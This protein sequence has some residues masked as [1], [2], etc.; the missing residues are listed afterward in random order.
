MRLFSVLVKTLDRHERFL[1]AALF[2]GVLIL[3]LSALQSAPLSEPEAA[4]AWGAL[5]LLRGETASG[6]SALYASITA[7]LFFLGGA[8]D[9]LARLL[10][11]IAGSALVLIPLALR[12]SRGKVEAFLFALLLAFSPA[13]A[14]VS[15]QAGGAAL[16]LVFAAFWIFRAQSDDPA[17]KDPRRDVTGGVLLGLALAAGPVGWSGAAIA[18]LCLPLDRLI[19]NA[20][21]AKGGIAARPMPI[22]AWERIRSG[23]GLLVAAVALAFGS[24][25]CLL[26]PRA[27]GALA[28][29]MT[30]WLGAFFSGLPRVGEIILMLA[31]YE[32][33]ALVFGSAGL[34]LYLRGSRPPEDRFLVLFVSIATVWVLVRPGAF[35]EEM[36]WILFPILILAARALC[37]VLELAEQ[38]ENPRIILAQVG[39]VLL[40]MVFAVFSLTQYAASGEIPKILLAI[41]AFL[42]S[43]IAGPLFIQKWET[44][45]RQSLV[46]LAL[47]WLVLLLC[48]QAGAGWNLA[49][50]R[51][52]STGELW[53]PETVPADI[54]RLRSTLEEFSNRLTGAADE[55]PVVLQWPEE[56]ALGWELQTYRAAQYLDAASQPAGAPALFISPLLE[57]DGQMVAPRRSA[58]Y[59]GQAF[60][61]REIRGWGGVPPDLVAWWLYRDGVALR[62]KVVLWVRT[63]LLGG[64][65]E[66]TP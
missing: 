39:I 46:G 31:A 36:V 47:G 55:L 61:V 59:R 3:R 6:A 18:L 30:S 42:A 1:Y 32:P 17:A 37:S 40:L 4:Q 51:R 63:D 8:A 56:S 2:L 33:I 49:H 52:A 64:A 19:R 35:P 58:D 15:A 41:L 53:W 27:I 5:R 38:E 16:G 9:W 12:S 29:G 14:A 22:G 26:F 62:E 23:R 66:T 60:A 11:A 65:E 24:T 13:T 57:Q 44:A 7:I 50:G 25:A 48:A 54:R 28:G 21:R 10:P 34:I 45:W 43:L 20:R